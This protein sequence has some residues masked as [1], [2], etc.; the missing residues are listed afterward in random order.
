MTIDHLGSAVS[1]GRH[2]LHAMLVPFPIVCF[3]G[4]FV[5]DL[6]YWQTLDVMWERFS[7]W[8][9]TAGVIMSV[10][11]AL[12]GMAALVSRRRIRPRHPLLHGLGNFLV[13]ALAVLNAFVHSRDGYTAVVPQGLILSGLVVLILIFTVRMGEDS[14]YRPGVGVVS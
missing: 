5:T 14:V 13:L 4:T 8:L 6:T 2:P 11:A 7:L 1:I 12:A 3:V 9:L 10:L